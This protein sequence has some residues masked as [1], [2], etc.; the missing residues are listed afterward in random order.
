MTGP[1]LTEKCSKVKGQ[2]FQE[3]LTFDHLYFL[4]TKLRQIIPKV[5]R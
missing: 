1:V 4:K 3:N 5:A 2:F